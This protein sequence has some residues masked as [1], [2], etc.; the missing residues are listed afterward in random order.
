[1]HTL[2]PHAAQ[3]AV[4]RVG[5][6]SRRTLWLLLLGVLGLHGLL[7]FGLSNPLALRLPT[8]D[9]YAAGP[10]QTRLLAAPAAPQAAPAP[11]RST[12]PRTR[13]A[14]EPA[15]ANQPAPKP[16]PQ[17]APEP[18]PKTSAD[19]SQTPSTLNSPSPAE[20]PVTAEAPPNTNLNTPLETPAQSAA[21]ASG[22]A[23]STSAPT[24]TPIS[25]PAS[26][27]EPLAQA[28]DASPTAAAISPIAANATLPMIP[29]GALPPSSLMTYRMTG[30]SKNMTYYANGELRWQYNDS[31]YAMS[32]TVKAFLLGTR[33]LKSVGVLN[34]TG[35][36]PVRFSDHWRSERAAHFDRENKK[37]VFSNNAPSAA[38]ESGAQDQ[39]SLYLQMAAA[40]A[41]DPL[42]FQPGTRL[43]IQTAT[44]R[45]AL[46]WLL[47]FEATETLKLEE[48]TLATAKW[49]CL[50]RNRFDAQVTFWMA[51][52]YAWM[53]VRIKITQA[54]GDF[55]D[56]TLKAQEPLPMLP[57]S[58][59]VTEKTTP[60]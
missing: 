27:S 7:M 19:P 53:P 34:A 25:T 43:Q 60:S 52:K 13:I 16:S 17:S 6:P 32:L 1:M 39:I 9:A 51:E 2:R 50:P 24:A 46:P 36:A 18:S 20:A 11:N 15:P 21:Q 38:L 57:V 35:L 42:R 4:T 37:V 10:L 8:D 28:R 47:T 44:L 48:Q 40:M 59:A 45:D 54:N 5:P 30:L 41:G 22:Q 23:A 14:T 55:I 49:V 3:N 56:L 33:Q 31:A 12:A 58:A 26:A 29:L